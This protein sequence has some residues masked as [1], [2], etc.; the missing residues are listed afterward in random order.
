MFQI[1]LDFIN[2]VFL[3]TQRNESV[4]QR[5]GL[6]SPFLRSMLRRYLSSILLF[7]HRPHSLHQFLLSIVLS[8]GCFKNFEVGYYWM[9]TYT[10]IYM[11]NK[12][13]FLCIDA[14]FNHSRC[15]IYQI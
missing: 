7:K 15:C 9:C 2:T 13:L 12:C 6:F 8:G 14:G 1:E 10:C 3:T 5:I 4:D 11:Y